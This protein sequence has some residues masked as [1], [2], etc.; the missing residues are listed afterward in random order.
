MISIKTNAEHKNSKKRGK[1]FLPCGV[2]CHFQLYTLWGL[3]GMQK[4]IEFTL[5]VI[6]SIFFE[7]SDFHL[8]FRWSFSVFFVFWCQ[9][10]FHIGRFLQHSK[11]EFNILRVVDWLF[12]FWPSGNICKS[13]TKLQGLALNNETELISLAQWNLKD[14][15]IAQNQTFK[16]TQSRM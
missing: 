9:S 14:M 5:G 10:T 3:V 11:N 12:C 6:N 16:S 2:L 1:V 8:D 7:E 13:F 4:F 15:K